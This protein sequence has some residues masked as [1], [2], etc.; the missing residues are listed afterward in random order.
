MH[1]MFKSDNTITGYYYYD[2][3]RAKGNKATISLK[4]IYTGE[5]DSGELSLKELN[6]SGQEIGVFFCNLNGGHL[7]DRDN[8]IVTY[9]H[10]ISGGSGYRNYN[11][12]KV[13]PVDLECAEIREL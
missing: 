10:W 5:V 3:Q 7:T 12:G 4:G 13:Y 11:S 6:A 9:M 8:G 1:L 2:S